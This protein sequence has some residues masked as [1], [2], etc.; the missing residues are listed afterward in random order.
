MKGSASIRH[1]FFT[2]VLFT[3]IIVDSTGLEFMAGQNFCPWL[4]LTQPLEGGEESGIEPSFATSEASSE[5][6]TS[7]HS[8][9]SLFDVDFGSGF[10]TPITS[11][12]THE[13]SSQTLT[14]AEA[15]YLTQKVD[16]GKENTDRFYAETQPQYCSLDMLSN[17][18]FPSRQGSIDKTEY[19]TLFDASAT[20]RSYGKDTSDRLSSK[21]VIGPS[22]A[23]LLTYG[24][25]DH[26]EPF[27]SIE[28]DLPP[29]REQSI[30]LGP[31]ET[32]IGDED[33]SPCPSMIESDDS[34]VEDI[35]LR[36]AFA[37]PYFRLDPVRHIECLSRKLYR[38]Q[39]VK[40]HLSRRHYIKRDYSDNTRGVNPRTQKVLKLRLDRR[41]SPEGQ[42]HEIW[43]TLFDGTLPREGP[44]LGNSK[45]E[46]VGS[47]IA[48][49]E[50]LFSGF[51]ALSDEQS[52]STETEKPPTCGGVDSIPMTPK[53]MEFEFDFNVPLHRSPLPEIHDSYSSK[54]M[55]ELQESNSVIPT[56]LPDYATFEGN[57]EDDILMGY[58]SEKQLDADVQVKPAWLPNTALHTPNV[59]ERSETAC[60]T[61]NTEHT[62]KSLT[63]LTHVLEETNDPDPYEYV[64][65]WA[66]DYCGFEYIFRPRGASSDMLCFNYPC[67]GRLP[68]CYY[69]SVYKARVR[70]D[71]L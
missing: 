24:I 49:M 1:L 13:K 71:R 65:A 42:W 7:Q 2:A 48:L 54:D 18:N 21:K 35:E 23:L 5:L 10:S 59:I 64:D 33:G 39:D 31:T 20:Y 53:D 28:E 66:C 22:S 68:G 67:L 30:P 44:Y 58:Q 70:R 19:I 56:E 51:Q 8:M 47:M 27:Q 16:R 15:L 41:L 45:E 57:G 37:C 3:G 55:T 11:Y 63:C 40:Q 69:D 17:T 61:I 6:F 52:N 25:G 36:K 50:Q 60:A 32:C 38:I 46:I 34:S 43:R 62:G 14:F 9:A 12:T 4:Q 26:L 29:S